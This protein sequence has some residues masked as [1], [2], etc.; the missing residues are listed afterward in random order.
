MLYAVKAMYVYATVAL[1]LSEFP[2]AFT[3]FPGVIISTILDFDDSKADNEKLV[4]LKSFY[5][6]FC[7]F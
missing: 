2:F 3:Q 6:K 4:R 5:K 1:K 7:L